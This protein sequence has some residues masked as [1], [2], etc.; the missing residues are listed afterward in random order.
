MK[1][2]NFIKI[3]GYIMLKIYNNIFDVMERKQLFFT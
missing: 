3:T 2:K 1:C